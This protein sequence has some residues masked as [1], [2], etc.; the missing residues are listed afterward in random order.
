MSPAGAREARGCRVYLVRHG[1]TVMNV[2]VRFRGVRD[3][4]L[5]DVGRREAWA[6]ARGLAGAG[7]TA[8][9]SSPLGRAMEVA[10]AISTVTGTGPVRRLDD[11]L[12]LDYGEW[13]GLTRE[14]SMAADPEAF[15]RY[16]NDPER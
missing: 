8:V 16:L 13:E 1:Q 12:N 9:Y 3:V 2:S 14:E 11:L 5:N 6:T 15:G 7:L 4:P 10:E